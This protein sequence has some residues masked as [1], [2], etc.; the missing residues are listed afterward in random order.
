MVNIMGGEQPL[1]DFGR[2]ISDLCSRKRSLV[3]L[4][5][6]DYILKSFI[7]Y[8]YYYTAFFIDLKASLWQR[9]LT[10]YFIISLSFWDLD[11]ALSLF[12][13]VRWLMLLSYPV[14]KMGSQPSWVPTRD[15]CTGCTYSVLHFPSIFMPWHC[16]IDRLWMIFL[17]QCGIRGSPV[18][19]NSV[20]RWNMWWFG[21]IIKAV[22]CIV[23]FKRQGSR[24]E[25]LR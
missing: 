22:L 21:G 20:L 3:A 10:R 1:T 13:R 16:H 12:S 4:K 9:S 18:C 8:N 15:L 19:P 6:N 17:D 25:L 5:K 14:L 2:R 11:S 7:N 23:L 24:Q